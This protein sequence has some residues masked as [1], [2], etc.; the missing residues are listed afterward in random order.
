MK[1]FVWLTIFL[2]W[3]FYLL[4]ES[5]FLLTAESAENAEYRGISRRK[6]RC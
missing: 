3:P 5:F 1:V 2:S 6:E 4:C